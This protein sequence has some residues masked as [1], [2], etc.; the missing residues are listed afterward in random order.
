MPCPGARAAPDPWHGFCLVIEKICELHNRLFGAPGD[1]LP[2]K[3]LDFAT[4]LSGV[5]HL[6][7]AK[8]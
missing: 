7:Y 1:K 8:A 3:L 6:S 4:F 2:L 5:V